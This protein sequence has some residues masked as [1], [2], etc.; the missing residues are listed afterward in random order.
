MPSA[1]GELAGTGS[2][3]GALGQEGRPGGVLHAPAF[4]SWDLRVLTCMM[5]TQL[6]GELPGS[7]ESCVDAGSPSHL[8]WRRR[9]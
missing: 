7:R 5:G 1:E 3:A 4:P 6:A 8:L 2:G 9:Q